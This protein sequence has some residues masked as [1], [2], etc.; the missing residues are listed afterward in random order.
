MAFT[1]RA[2]KAAGGR[3]FLA[4]WLLALAMFVALGAARG[5]P[6]EAA[7]PQV[8][9]PRQV[10]TFDIGPEMIVNGTPAR[11]RGFVSHASPTEVAESFR[12]VLGRPLVEDRRGNMLVLGRGEGRYYMT[13]Q[14]Q[15]FGS[16]TRGLLAVTTPTLKQRDAADAGAARRLLSALPPGSTLASHT[17]SVDG[18]I[19]AEHDAIVN[20]HSVDVNT[21]YVTRMLRAS[22]FVL[23]HEAGP[24]ATAD[25]RM[26][27]AGNARTLFFKRAGGEAVAV[28]FTADSGKSVIVLNRT[29]FTGRMQ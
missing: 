11:M 10:D 5:A 1:T 29:S 2:Q 27:T 6:A 18:A 8:R 24:S 16:G 28:L 9:I 23:E 21:E 13:V 17:S 3:L 22:G 7:W 14:I 26:R 12:Q 20:S 25:W 4:H 19:R 15:P